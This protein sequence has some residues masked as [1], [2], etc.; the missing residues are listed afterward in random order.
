MLRIF[1][2]VA[3]T[4]GCLT[5]TQAADRPNVLFISVDDLNDWV[6]LFGGHP[7]GADAAY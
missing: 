4:H 6:S 3:L 5:I 7:Q 1:F 2:V